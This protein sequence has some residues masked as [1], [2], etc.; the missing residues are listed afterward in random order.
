[1][2]IGS[3]D[4]ITGLGCASHLAVALDLDRRTEFARKAQHTAIKPYVLAFGR[5]AQL[6]AMPLIG[7]PEAW[8]APSIIFILQE[9]LKGLRET[10]GETLHRCGRNAGRATT[11]K[12]LVQIVAVQERACLRIVLFLALQHLVVEQARFVQTGIQATAL[13]S[14]WVQAKL[15]RSHTP[16]YTRLGTLYQTNV[17]MCVAQLQ[18]AE[19]RPASGHP[20]RTAI[21]LP[22]KVGSPLAHF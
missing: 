12:S 7:R 13:F 17:R 10:S 6:D 18:C 11:S 19:P 14:V 1:V 5:L 22:P 3:L 8:K 20:R 16:I 9:V 21:H 4:Q 15:I 2:T